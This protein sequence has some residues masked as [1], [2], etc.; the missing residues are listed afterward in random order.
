MEMFRF[1]Q[2]ETYRPRRQEDHAGVTAMAYG[3]CRLTD[4]YWWDFDD[5]AF[6]ASVDN[7]Q[8]NA[9]T[10][11]DNGFYIDATGWAI[12]DSNAQYAVQYKVSDATGDFYREGP[13]IVVNDTGPTVETG[14]TLQHCLQAVFSFCAALATGGATDTLRYR[15]Y[16]DGKNRMTVTVDA[17]GNR[18]TIVY[19]FD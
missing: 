17:N 9:M 13:L 7:T 19:S 1:Y 5:G 18:S 2:S 3:I 8:Y 11:D 4:G 10:E 12:P 14:L 6:E 15:D 16:A